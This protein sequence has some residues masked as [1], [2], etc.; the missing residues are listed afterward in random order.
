[1]LFLCLKRHFSSSCPL[2][3][4]AANPG[5]S[6]ILTSEALASSL[7]SRLPEARLVTLTEVNAGTERG[8]LPCM[9]S[10]DTALIQFTSG[11][12]SAP[13]GVLLSHSQLVANGGAIQ[14][15]LEVDPARDTGVGWLP[16]HHD[17]GLIGFLITPRFDPGLH[18]V[19]TTTGCCELKQNFMD[20][21]VR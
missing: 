17:M 15:V 2:E 8:E 7:Q 4:T 6:L 20:S 19:F 13:K 21:L 12:T 16:L 1:M 18:L 5:A 14:K 9:K 10:Y 11:S 3:I